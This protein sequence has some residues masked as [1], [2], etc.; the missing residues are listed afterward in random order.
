MTMLNLL[1][2]AL[3]LGLIEYTKPGALLG[4]WSALKSLWNRHA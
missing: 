2:V 1:I 3:L 4:I